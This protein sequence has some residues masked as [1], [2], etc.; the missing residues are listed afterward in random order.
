MEVWNEKWD[1]FIGKPFRRIP[2]PVIYPFIFLMNSFVNGEMGPSG[3]ACGCGRGEK[4]RM[5]RSISVTADWQMSVGMICG[6]VLCGPSLGLARPNPVGNKEAKWSWLL[7]FLP[8]LLIII[9]Q[10]TNT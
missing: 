8:N 2:D 6:L 9:T 3:I 4:V 7:L 5:E 10:L 1:P